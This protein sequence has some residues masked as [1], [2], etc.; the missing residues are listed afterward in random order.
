M[1]YNYANERPSIQRGAFFSQVVLSPNL[2]SASIVAK[3][4]R[5]GRAV[6]ASSSSQEGSIGL[7]PFHDDEHPSFGVNDEGNYWHCFAGCGG[8]NVID[9]WMKYRNCNFMTAVKELAEMLL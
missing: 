2:D 8:G 1:D 6:Q 4:R 5:R 7:C 9:F 3:E